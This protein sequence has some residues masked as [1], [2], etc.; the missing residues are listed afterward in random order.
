MSEVLVVDRAALFGGDW[1]QGFVPMAPAAG[2]RLLADAHRLSRFVDRDTAERTPAWKQWIPYCFLRC[3]GAGEA[4]VFCVRRTRGQSEARLH[5]LWSIGLGGHIEPVD[6]PQPAAPRGNPE[7]AA[8][9]FFAAALRREL[10]EE[11]SIQQGLAIEPRLLGLL[12][13]DNTP[14]GEVHAGLV[15]VWDVP[16]PLPAARTAV[17]VGEIGKMAG[18]FTSLVEFGDLWQNPQQFE[19]WSRFLLESGIVLGNGC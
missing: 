11:L 7:L 14:V 18:G 4:G 3:Q 19:S 8:A 15:Y 12:N 13:D 1:P 6:A 9:A 17:A 5:G 2:Q 16:L 10:T